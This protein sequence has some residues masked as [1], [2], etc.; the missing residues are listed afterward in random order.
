MLTIFTFAE[1][2]AQ[3]IGWADAGRLMV[4]FP[5]PGTGA[6]LDGLVASGAA[7]RR[8][9]PISST[10]SM[11]L[12]GA[13]PTGDSKRTWSADDFHE[14]IPAPDGGPSAPQKFNIVG[15]ATAA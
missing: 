3:L 2:Y 9:V 12:V 11:S 7:V 8:T 13:L 1:A 10:K 14:V 5:G 15:V 4:R 6:Y